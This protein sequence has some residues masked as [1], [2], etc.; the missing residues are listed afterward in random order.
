MTDRSLPSTVQ[1]P[2]YKCKLHL[3]APWDSGASLKTTGANFSLFAMDGLVLPH[4]TAADWI[5][6]RRLTIQERTNAF[7]KVVKP[8]FSLFFPG[9]RSI[10]SQPMMIIICIKFFCTFPC[11]ALKPGQFVSRRD[12][13]WACRQNNADSF[14]GWLQ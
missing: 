4:H 6:G 10:K 9:I 3:L 2:Q 8:V 5:E 1:T 13:R 11:T 7:S 14:R 12:E